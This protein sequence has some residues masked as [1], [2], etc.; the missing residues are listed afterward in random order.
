[1]IRADGARAAASRWAAAGLLALALPVVPL[2]VAAVGA[3]TL[4][5]GI[6][7][8]GAAGLAALAAWLGPAAW[9]GTGRAPAVERVL[10]T[11]TVAWVAALD[12]AIAGMAV[13]GGDAS[14]TPGPVGLTAGVYVLGSMWSIRTPAE[15]WW[16][17]PVAC[18][19]TGA[20]WIVTQAAA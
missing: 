15:V 11:A 4:T 7:G 2:A 16:R 10:V 5:L 20:T 6:L 19:L 1:V 12:A 3:G 8:G 18:A 14:I 9:P 13:H 17:W